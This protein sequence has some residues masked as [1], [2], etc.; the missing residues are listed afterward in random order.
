MYIQPT[1]QP[2]RPQIKEYAPSFLPETSEKSISNG[3]KGEGPLSKGAGAHSSPYGG[4]NAIDSGRELPLLHMNL[5]H[6][7]ALTIGRVTA[8][9]CFSPLLPCSP[10]PLSDLS[11]VKVT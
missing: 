9:I 1:N 3:K 10:A 5:S 6:P 7:Q 11:L 8:L 4:H 2:T